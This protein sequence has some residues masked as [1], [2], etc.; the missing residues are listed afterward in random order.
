MVLLMIHYGRNCSEGS[1]RTSRDEVDHTFGK[2]SFFKDT[3]P[4]ED[5]SPVSLMKKALPV[6]T[7]GAI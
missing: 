3:F 5:S 7:A 2:E 1:D 4:L 6:V